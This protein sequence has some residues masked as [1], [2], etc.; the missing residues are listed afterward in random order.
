MYDAILRYAEKLVHYV[1]KI[2]LLHLY[3]IVSFIFETVVFIRFLYVSIQ[4]WNNF[5]N[6][7]LYIS[8]FLFIMTKRLTA[9]IRKNNT[10]PNVYN[11]ILIATVCFIIAWRPM[12]HMIEL[13]GWRR[14]IFFGGRKPCGQSSCTRDTSVRLLNADPPAVYN[15]RGYFPTGEKTHY[16]TKGETKYVYCD[17][18]DECTWAD[19]HDKEPIQGYYKFQGGCQLDYDDPARPENGF[20]STRW[21]DCIDPGRGVLNGYAPCKRIGQ[22]VPCPGQYNQGTTPNDD[23]DHNPEVK[24]YGDDDSKSYKY[25]KGKRVCSWCSLYKTSVKRFGPLD[26]VPEFAEK[27][28]DCIPPPDG[29]IAVLCG[30]MCPGEPS[31]FSNPF[32]AYRLETHKKKHIANNFT[33]AMLFSFGPIVSYIFAYVL[34][35]ASTSLPPVAEPVYD[36]EGNTVPEP[37]NSRIRL[38]VLHRTI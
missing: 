17:Y 29:H 36:D 26:G 11:Y 6:V 15:P 1:Q 14:Y 32:K 35:R 8:P 4:H 13:N 7:V 2:N 37:I 3:H 9:I 20:M 27:H 31:L 38:R 19:Y 33:F 28:T 34:A 30:F 12:F 18:E 10:W 5:Y 24:L 23:K 21:E 22:S 16:D 25:F